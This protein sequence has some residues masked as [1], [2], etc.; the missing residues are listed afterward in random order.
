MKNFSTNNKGLVTFF[1]AFLISCQFSAQN[2][3]SSSDWQKDLRF[4]QTTVHEDYPFLFKKITG[5]QFDEKVDQ[6][7]DAIPEMEEHEIVAGL[8]RI[9]SSFEYG[10][11]SINFS[12][13]PVKFHLLPFNLYHFSDGVFIEGIHK[14]YDRALGAKI[15]H[16]EGVPIDEGLLAIRPVVPAE[17]DQFF[18]GYGLRYLGIPEVL[19]AQ[20]VI[21]TLKKEIAFTLEKNGQSFEQKIR[22]VDFQRLP[23]AYGFIRPGGDWRS[24]R[25]QNQTPYYI[26]R[27]NKIYYYEYLPDTKTV[28]VRHSQIQDDADQDIPTFYNKL[29]DFIDKNEV[30]R[31]VLDVRLNGGGNNYKNKPIITGIIRSKKINELGKLFVI[32]GRRTFSA[33]QNLVNELDNYTNALFVGE[34]TSENINFYGDNRQVV[35]PN[36]NMPVS[37]SFAWWQDK[38]QWENAPWTTPDLA[39]EMSFDDYRFNRDPILEAALSF[40]SADFILNPMAHLTKLFES[41]KLDEVEKEAEQMVLDPRYRFFNFE[42]EFNQAGYNLMN[43]NRIKEAIFVFQ[44]NSRFFPESA[45]C[46]DSLAEAYLKANDTDKAVKF[47]EKAIQLDSE[48]RIGE[49]ARTML[50]RIKGR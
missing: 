49:N 26:K 15:T 1:F 9:V 40:S 13:S 36:S 8:A 47:Y 42:G 18:K 39:V 29:F 3:M 23:S 11:T 6:L 44:M 31:L 46:Y 28:Y 32:I 30:D 35:L 17:N 10:H 5:K 41:N 37:L 27:L 50:K 2:T 25:N 38:P 22:A 7:F 12:N 33:C 20:K 24:V 34:P 45:N 14:D 21:K 16:V 4:L 48:G 19:H 43:N